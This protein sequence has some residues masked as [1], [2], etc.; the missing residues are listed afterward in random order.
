M[1]ER[2]APGVLRGCAGWGGGGEEQGRGGRERGIG[3]VV[4]QSV[5]GARLRGVLA[6]QL[7]RGIGLVVGQQGRQE[8]GSN[9]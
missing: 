7:E 6:S 3:L 4:G 1:K 9:K 5:L 2:G 8:G